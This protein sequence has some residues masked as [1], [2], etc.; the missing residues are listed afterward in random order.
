MRL[1]CLC[2]KEV[3]NVCDCK[4]LGCITDIEFDERT[5]CIEAFIV[6]GPGHFGGL[7]GRDIEYVI[8]F[9]CVRQVGKDIVLVEVDLKD[10]IK[11]C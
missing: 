7:F 10:C 6:P 11:K 2:D 4:R 3:I 9:C 8:P 1:L 5:G